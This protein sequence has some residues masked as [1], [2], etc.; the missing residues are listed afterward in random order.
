MIQSP[1]IR[2]GTVAA[3]QHG[4]VTVEQALKLGLSRNSIYSRVRRGE[5]QRLERGVLLVTP[6]DLPNPWH[7][8]V[9]AALLR[10]GPS[11][12]AGLGTA[13]QLLGMAGHDTDLDVIQLILPRGVERAQTPGIR[14][15]F[16]DVPESAVICQGSIR[17]TDPVATLADLVPQLGRNRGVAVLDSALNRRLLTLDEL[18]E[19]KALTA[20][21][22]GAAKAAAWWALADA[23]ADSP[24][25]SWSRLDCY[26]NGLAPDQLQWAVRD[27][28]GRLLGLGDMAWLSRQRPVVGEADGAEPHGTPSAVYRDRRRANN[29]VGAG[30]DIVRFTWADARRPGRCAAIVRHALATEPADL[31]RRLR[32]G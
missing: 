17:C 23:R 26:D 29:F 2:I 20:H 3:Q 6:G 12:V 22:P 15:H 1:D 7:T 9:Q 25:E 4:V 32:S 18:A 30:V 21:R 19:A 5:Y 10:H 16:R 28:H 14:L 13:A 31:K 11:A 27:R 8:R 24:L